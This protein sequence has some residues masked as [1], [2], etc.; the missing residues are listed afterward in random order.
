MAQVDFPVNPPPDESQ[1]PT[2]L[3]TNNLHPQ[4][5]KFQDYFTFNTD[6]KVIGIQYLVTA[7]VFYF[8]GGL[9]AITFP[10][11]LVTPD[12][13]FLN[14]NF[15][16][17]FMINH[18]TIMIFIWIVLSTIGGFG[19]YLVPLMIGARDMAFPKLNTIAFWLN[20]PAGLLLLLSFIFDGSQSGWTA[21]LPLNLITANNAQIFWILAIVLL[22]TSLILSYIN[23]VITILTMKVTNMK[24]HQ[25]P[26]FCWA[27]LVTSMLA[28]LSIVVLVTGSAILLF[29]INFGTSF[30]NLD[31]GD[32]VIIYQHLFWLYSR[33]AVY[34]MILPI[35]GIMSEVISTHTQRPI[36]SYQAIAYVSVAICVVCLWVWVHHLFTSE[37]PNWMRILFTIST[38]IIAVFTGMKIFSWV[39][40][41]WSLK[42][43]FTSAILFAI[44]CLSSI[45]MGIAPFNVHNTYYLFTHFYYVLFSS[46]IFGIYAGIYHW[47]P[48][49]IG[50]M[51][52]E[53]W[54][55]IHFLLT[56]IG[57]NL[58]FLSMHELDLQGMSP[59]FIGLNQLSTIGV[60][61]LGLS[62]IPFTFNA[63]FSWRKGEFAGDNPWQSLTL[64]WKTSSPPII[65]NWEVLPVV[66]HR[67][68]DYNP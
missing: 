48:K 32:N 40:T 46:S 11:K 61:I 41:L 42:I 51:I 16:N 33:L 23:L 68:Y 1:A 67:P 37:T 49:M 29:N 54:G 3:V 39:A 28:I 66:T 35:F 5:W 13:N 24:W 65:E 26:L 9:I 53:P 18:G 62:V 6:H 7:F 20:P 21:Y 2:R 30:F 64:E 44:G 57:T 19:N 50:R 31:G 38:L 25:L 63:I 14:P 52:N 55:R 36:F 10:T 59:Q 47:F 22:G 58:T 27:I 12:S 60:F 45:I 34:L 8:I 15:Y 43:R 17:A 4:S 56:F